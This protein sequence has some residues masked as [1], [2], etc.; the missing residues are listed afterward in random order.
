MSILFISKKD[1]ARLDFILP[2]LL[3]IRKKYPTMEINI[4][5]CSLQ[6]N[7]I[8]KNSNYYSMHFFNNNIN[9]YSLSLFLKSPWGLLFSLYKYL[10]S[11]VNSNSINKVHK[12]NKICIYVKKIFEKI[13]INYE[14]LL[15]D[16]V[17]TKAILPYFKPQKVL[18]DN[19]T[20]PVFKGLPIFEQYFKENNT[21]VFLVPHAPTTGS[22]T[23]NFMPF[24]KDERLPEYCEY[25]MPYKHD[26]CWEVIPEKKSQ[27]H[28]VGYPGM[29]TKWLSMVSTKKSNNRNTKRL[30]VG[31][32]YINCLFIIR[33]FLPPGC[34]PDE[35]FIISYTEFQK[36]LNLITKAIVHSNANINLIVKPHPSTDCSLLHTMLN[37]Y[38]IPNWEIAH[39]PIYPLL[40]KID[41]VVSLYSTILLVPAIHQIPTV[42]LKINVQ[43]KVNQDP[44]YNK[45]YT[46]LKFYLEDP[47]ELIPL[48]P[49]LIKIVRGEKPPE[50]QCVLDDQDHLR[51]LWPDK[52]I[53]KCMNRLGLS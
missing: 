29:D 16:K 41:F 23:T 37:N 6:K 21:K 42:L 13:L 30:G 27:F 45:I 3:Q 28:Y 31:T 35:D 9:E 19:T 36:Y 24:N 52:S 49:T 46:N 33:R 8:L 50:Y 22:Y 17:K 39:E 12:N 10:S 4:L 2:V 26:R 44:D 5:Y 34:E 43:D 11:I 25:W 15:L 18:Y 38:E 47:S 48:F 40:S 53:D 1:T 20:Y 7:R 14:V 32:S 51:K